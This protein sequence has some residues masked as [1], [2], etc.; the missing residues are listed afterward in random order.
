MDKTVRRI[1]YMQSQ[2][3]RPLYYRSLR[4]EKIIGVGYQVVRRI[5]YPD[6]TE[7]TRLEIAA[8][9]MVEIVVPGSQERKIVKT[10]EIQI[11]ADFTDEPKWV[12]ASV[13][14]KT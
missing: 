9:D 2:S 12:I 8:G 4:D 14:K 10:L 7:N 5:L 13:T 11:D 3:N 1:V 6:L